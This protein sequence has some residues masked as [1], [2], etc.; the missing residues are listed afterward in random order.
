MLKISKWG[1]SKRKKSAKLETGQSLVEFAIMLPIL[2]LVVMGIIE[3]GFIMNSYLTLQNAA[4]EGA[5]AGALGSS[6]S[7]VESIIKTGSTG[8][9]QDSITV[10]VIP[11]DGSR[12]TGKML[13][14]K[15]TY[16]Y[17]L[18]VP[19]INNIFAD[20]TIPLQ[21]EVSMRIE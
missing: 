19:I 11:E 13:T 18:N 17:N 16:K 9:I 14:V 1:L 5:R 4:R 10:T 7:A 6:N 8:L 12:H 15:V 21:A 2:L 20:K 3:F